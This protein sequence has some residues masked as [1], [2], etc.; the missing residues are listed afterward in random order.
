LTAIATV[1]DLP[2]TADLEDG[3][4]QDDSRLT[5]FIQKVLDVGVAG[6]NIEDSSGGTLVEM[7]SQ[8]RRIEVIRAAADSIG[9]DLFI[10]AR[11][12][13][14]FYGSSDAAQRDAECLKRAYTYVA[15]GADGI[16]VPGIDD[17]PTVSTLSTALPVPLNIMVGPGSPVVAELLDAGAGRITTGMAGALAAYAQVEQAAQNLLRL[18]TYEALSPALDFGQFDASMR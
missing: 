5:A 12:D 13:T 7:S 17:L 1:T 4:E 16:F 11:V 10:N 14:A 15:A 6:I 3:Y 18:G 9:A 2:L 8:A